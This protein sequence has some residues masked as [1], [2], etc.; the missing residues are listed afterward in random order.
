MLSSLESDV[1]SALPSHAPIEIIG[2]AN[3][4]SANGVAN[5]SG[6][7]GD[8][9]IIENYDISAATADGIEIRDTTAHF[10]IQNVNIQARQGVA[11]REFL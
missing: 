3:F 1:V 7:E 8:P 11:V 10:I 2:D 5:G 9:Y 4:T 6:T